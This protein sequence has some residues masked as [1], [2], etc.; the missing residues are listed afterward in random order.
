MSCLRAAAAVVGAAVLLTACSVHPNDN[1]LPGQVAVG[2]DGYTAYVTFDQVENLVPNSTVQMGDVVIGTVAKIAVHDWRAR[3]T[4]RLRKNVAVPENAVFTIGQKTLLGAQYVQV[5]APAKPRGR[6]A[7]NADVP[8]S[9]TGTYPATEQVLASASLLLN[10]GGLSQISTITGE[11]N[12][13]LDQR[14]PDTQSVIRRLNLLLGT[15]EANKK[16][17]VDTLE[18]LDRLSTT[19]VAQR[20]TIARALDTIGPALRTLDDERATL[21]DTTTRLGETS[22]KG[23]EVLTASSEA[24]LTTLG[25][26][27]PT[28]GELAKVAADLPDALKLLVS[29]PFPIMTASNAVRGDYANLFATVDLRLPTLAKNFGLDLSLLETLSKDRAADAE[30]AP[31]AGDAPAPVKGAAPPPGQATATPSPPARP[32]PTPIPASDC[33]IL[34][35]LGVC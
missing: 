15:L 21:V 27:R 18:S 26:L 24:F 33:G 7:A 25:A 6:L 30:A 35:L 9:Q 17:I 14:V 29:L 4:L 2:N 11:L 22:V 31:V 19:A 1:T 16:E 32:S 10:N 13:T 8:V 5:D 34:K 3:L 12:K 28:L 23:S 20:K